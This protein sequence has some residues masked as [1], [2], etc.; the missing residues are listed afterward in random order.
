[1]SNKLRNPFKIRAS[2]KIDSEAGF[3]RLFSPLVLESL[4]EKYQSGKLWDNVLYIHS[5]PGA[6][7]SSLI[8]VFEPSTLKILINGKSSPDYK[9]LFNSLKRIEVINQEKIEV[10]SVSMQCTRN[11]EILEELN[12]SLAQKTRFFF[13]LLNSRIAIATL[14]SAC[15]MINK[16]APED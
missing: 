11:Y 13:S 7:K 9:E 2:E 4:N 14:R 10:L 16:K 1:M 6:G 15:V 8:R 12:I 3:L 5:S